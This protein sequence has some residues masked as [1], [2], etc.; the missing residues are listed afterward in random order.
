MV[1]PSVAP[2]FPSTRASAVAGLRDPAR[3]K[4]SWQRVVAAY[5][6]PVYAH[7]R[8]RWRMS[9]A[10][11][12]DLV[13]DFFGAAFEKAYLGGWQPGR[14]PFRA[15]L[16]LCVDRHAAKA[17]DATRAEKRG[18]GA[19]HL[20]LDFEGSEAELS[21]LAAPDVE[22]LWDAEWTR[23]VFALALDSMRQALRGT[24]QEPRL[25]AFERYDLAEPGDRPTYQALALE[26]GVPAT[27]VTNHLAWARRELK[28]HLLDTLRELTADEAELEREARAL[29]GE[30][31]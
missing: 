3:S 21:R 10:D 20:P 14:A 4:E 19:A 31:P 25:R 26:L 27:T 11:A 30:A 9:P 12:Q 7:L 1:A 16:K 2:G 22:A 13:Q 17:A 15:Y 18:G 24:A 5:W 29:L 6:R 8:L 28:R 23:R